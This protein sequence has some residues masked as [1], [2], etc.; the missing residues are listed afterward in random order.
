MSHPS[1]LL[2]ELDPERRKSLS[3]GLT[4]EG[5]EV[6]PS[7][8]AAEA[9]RFARGLGPTVIVIPVEL[10]RDE[11]GG[12]AP[13]F[14]IH[15]EGRTLLLLGERAEDGAGLEED[16]L[17][18]P[19]AGLEESELVRRIRLA[20]IGREIGVEPDYHLR[21]L[22]GDFSLVSPLD[23][24]RRLHRLAA[25]AR[26]EARGGDVFLQ[27]GEL[28]AVRCGAVR[29]LKAFG[30]LA[31][32]A[33]GPFR[34]LFGR[35]GH[36]ER[37]IR[38]EL[39]E[40]IHLAASD[41]LSGIP[42]LQTR[43][44][45]SFGP[46]LF[47]DPLTPMQQEILSVLH[48]GGSL[49]RVLDAS[50]APDGQILSEVHAMERRGVL[51]RL[52]PHP[53]VV[54]ITDST[55]DLPARLIEEH[56]IVVVPLTIHFGDEVFVDREQLEPA[57][58]YEFLKRR[59]EHPY[60]NPPSPEKF[61]LE[62]HRRLPRQDILSIHISS[63]LSQTF[64]HARQAS[65]EPQLREAAREIGKPDAL[66]VIDSGQVSLPLGLQAI[67]AARM[68][69]RG[70]GVDEIADRLAVIGPRMHT[71]F[72]VDTLDYLAKGGRIG[73]ARALLGKL[74]GIRPILGVENGEVVSVERVR[75]RRSALQR[76]VELAASRLEADRPTL[77]AIAHANAAARA[78]RLLEL[79]GRR[80][81]VAE[82]HVAEMG[83]VLGVHAGPGCV[84]AAFFQPSDE[85]GAVVAA[86]ERERDGS[87]AG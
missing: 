6:V 29:G 73:K 59:T 3:F 30:R 19:T 47:S 34:V 20:L 1:V 78:D 58:F 54:I 10:A 46:Q 68:A 82:V 42:D 23:L 75:G 55:C 84:G 22:V 67:L 7:I 61:A 69:E 85:E 53:D 25:T 65:E 60:T 38:E 64:A 26:V 87:S 62:Y 49:G 21:G 51:E 15:G 77:V 33:D 17:F 50:T 31:R 27:E 63:K 18:L 56:R 40:A 86:L 41:L 71:L 45:V 24:V 2:V 44:R 8:D 79:V 36:P 4:A 76:L 5:Y 11:S 57:S 48:E 43:Y 81:D 9:D 52:E 37:E 35:E 14:A 80:L 70:L 28:V 13:G 66:R 32:R 39:G 74:T 16:A 83:P 72:L 12:L